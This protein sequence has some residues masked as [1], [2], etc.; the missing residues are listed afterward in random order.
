MSRLRREVK[1]HTQR[2]RVELLKSLEEIFTLAKPLAKGE[3]QTQTV[4]GI[5]V[6][7]TLKERR[8]WARV[9]AYLAQIMNS[10]AEGYDEREINELLNE[11]EKMVREAK[12][13]GKAGEAEEGAGGP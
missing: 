4:D 13:K 2:I 6:K 9:A 12:A 1:V 5:Q 8:A 3:F 11:L 7:V 10:V